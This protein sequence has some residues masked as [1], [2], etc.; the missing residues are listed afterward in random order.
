ME[1]DCQK[2]GH[3]ESRRHQEGKSS[4]FLDIHHDANRRASRAWGWPGH[5]FV[6]AGY[7]QWSLDGNPAGV[8]LVLSAMACVALPTNVI[9]SNHDH[10]WHQTGTVLF[11]FL[12]YGMGLVL[13]LG[14]DVRPL[15]PFLKLSRK[16]SAPR[17]SDP[18]R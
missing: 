14:D 8:D 1:Y 18:L 16:E 13:S 6:F 2:Q 10:L 3:R 12:G 11:G 17:V 15:V 9:P 5:W 7:Y 4:E